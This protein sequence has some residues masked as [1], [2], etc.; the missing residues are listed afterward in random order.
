MAQQDTSAPSF[1]ENL[2]T[3]ETLVGKLETGEV[4]LDDALAQFEQGMALVSACRA[5]LDTAET[6][7]KNVMLSVNASDDE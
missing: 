1:E 3:L 4:K 5:Q 2:Q 6:T 7:I